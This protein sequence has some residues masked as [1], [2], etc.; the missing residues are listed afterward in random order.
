[1]THSLLIRRGA[2]FLLAL[3]LAAC[4]SA[5]G[6]TPPSPTQP[7]QAS[8]PARSPTS[9]ATKLPPTPTLAV[10]RLTA[11]ATAQPEAT[12]TQTQPAGESGNVSA[13]PDPQNTTWAALVSG[14]QRPTD[15]VDMGGGQMLVLEQPGRVRIIKDKLLLPDPFLDITSR[16]GS[17]GNEQGLLGI[18]LHPDFAANGLFYL[19]YTNLDGDTVIARFELPSGRCQGRPGQPED[20]ADHRSAVRQPQRRGVGFRAGRLPL[21]WPG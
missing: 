1:M 11:T 21:H 8:S 2:I 9:T 13:F 14:L 18:A 6:I 19:D 20:S 16:V 5:P 17:T 7:P 4:A 10:E 3:I 15:L 12:A